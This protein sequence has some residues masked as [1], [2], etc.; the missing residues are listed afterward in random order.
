[1]FVSDRSESPRMTARS[2]VWLVSALYAACVA[3]ARGTSAPLVALDRLAAIVDGP[4]GYSMRVDSHEELGDRSE[5]LS[6]LYRRTMP[7]D[8][9]S[10]RIVEG[11]GTG[12]VLASAP[13]GRV[14][15]LFGGSFATSTLSPNDARI[16]TLRGTSPRGAGLEAFVACAAAHRSDVTERAGPRIGGAATRAIVFARSPHVVCPNDAVADDAVSE[17]VV[18]V[19]QT[20]GRPVL[21]K[22]FEGRRI[23]VRWRIVDFV[24][25]R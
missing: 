11:R 21:R 9:A 1:M 20:D 13:D 23:V 16:A 14:R 6:Y 15:V 8:R 22:R 10:L 25:S 4:H 3:G 7:E 12:I 19:S 24:A 17:D 2:L 18:F 5:D